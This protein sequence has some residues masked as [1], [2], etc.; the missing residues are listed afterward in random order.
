MH[1]TDTLIKTCPQ[2]LMHK[3]F[4]LPPHLLRAA[5]IPVSR[6]VQHPGDLVITAPGAFH[7]GFNC[8]L[9][10]AEATNFAGASWWK[11]GFFHD[12]LAV[13]ACQCKQAPKFH[14][15][16]DALRHALGLVAAPFGIAKETL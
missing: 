16:D 7:F 2:A 11:D 14:F 9:N 10:L 1:P 5:G 6:I 8:G 4:L 15:E 12:S 13:G 3:V